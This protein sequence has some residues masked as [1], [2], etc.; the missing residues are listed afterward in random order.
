MQS[1]QAPI[2]RLRHFQRFALIPVVLAA[3]LASGCNKDDKGD[4]KAS[5][6][7][8]RVNGDEITVHQINMVLERQPNI[9]PEQAE[10]ASRQILE[11]LGESPG[12]GIGRQHRGHASGRD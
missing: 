1:N 7:A 5:Q 6:A 2:A 11:G 9:R 12:P 4:G 10:A 8:A 3:V